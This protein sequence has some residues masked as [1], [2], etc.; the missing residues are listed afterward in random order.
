DDGSDDESNDDSSNDDGS[1]DKSND[2]SSN[3]D[4][5]NDDSSND[6]NSNDD[7]DDES[8]EDD[9]S[10][11]E[12]SD[13]ESNDDDSSNDD[14]SDSDSSSD[15]TSST[16]TTQPEVTQPDVVEPE[17]NID[18]NQY[19]DF[20]T[21]GEYQGE[22]DL[23]YETLGTVNVSLN[24]KSYRFKIA[25]DNFQE[26]VQTPSFTSVGDGSFTIAITS[27][28][29][30]DDDILRK[31]DGI[32]TLVITVPSLNTSG[33]Y[34]VEANVL[35][36]S[37]QDTVYAQVNVSQDENGIIFNAMVSEFEVFNRTKTK[38]YSASFAVQ[39]DSK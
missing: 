6:T 16:Q 26:R 27:Y 23:D 22:D 9:D 3:D 32:F 7:S 25:K 35:T 30:T 15:T 24:N 5:S 8:S 38:S 19:L 17:Y 20:S 2:D 10:S 34:P 33:S 11:D 12:S 31:E 28:I 18:Q 1:N 39:Y 29:I 21:Y 4:E 13:D 14:S 36:N 37:A